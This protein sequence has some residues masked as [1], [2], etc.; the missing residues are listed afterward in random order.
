[1]SPRRLIGAAR[2]PLLVDER[3]VEYARF[4]RDFYPRDLPRGWAYCFACGR[5]WNDRKTTSVTPAPAARCP[6]EDEHD[7]SFEEMA[8]RVHPA[9]PT[10]EP[11]STE[12]R[13]CARPIKRV[14]GGHGPV[15]VHAETG[16]VIA[17]TPWEARA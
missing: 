12:C 1:M 13:W 16:A 4:L 9:D 15:W 10:P 11:D 6:F 2:R 3:G 8:G 5:A 17:A 14:P 7:L